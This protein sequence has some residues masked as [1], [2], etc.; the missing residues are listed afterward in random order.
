MKFATGFVVVTA[1]MSMGIN[2]AVKENDPTDDGKVFGGFDLSSVEVQAPVPVVPSAAAD[3]DASQDLKSWNKYLSETFTA[4]KAEVSEIDLGKAVPSAGRVADRIN[5]EEILNARLETRL[6]F[7]TSSGDTVRVS[8]SNAVNC[9]D[10]GG[11]CL[12]ND[13]SFFLFHTD[14]GETAFVRAKDIANLSVLMKGC[15]KI[16]FRGD[17]EPY[18]IKLMIK[19][20]SPRQSVLKV[21]RGGK[22]VLSF[23]MDQLAKAMNEK[24]V[25]LSAG[26]HHNFF[27]S[28]EVLQD[29]NG[30]GRFGPGRE[31]TFSPLN[32]DPC[33]F[34][35]ASRITSSGVALPSV[36][37]GYGFRILD[38]FLE[39]YPL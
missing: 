13:R 35:D 5:L 27:Y 12:E 38:G 8:A 37:R 23:T 17:K 4:V 9:A 26:S 29:R 10:G 20:T 39:I 11:D 6:T 33:Q 34:V 32:P 3:S 1:A 19:A 25:R 22:V 31:L 36:E 24:A 18:L 21:E 16:Y 7:M 28:V 15:K 2:A 30:N 14:S